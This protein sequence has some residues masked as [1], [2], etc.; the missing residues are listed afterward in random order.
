MTE[1]IH[2]LDADNMEIVRLVDDPVMY[3]RPWSCTTY[4]KRLQ[5]ELLEYICNENEKDVQHLLGK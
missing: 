4:P 1:R 5:G 3:T 2:R